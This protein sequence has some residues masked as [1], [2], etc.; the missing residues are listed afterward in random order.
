ME[1]FSDIA[2]R[3]MILDIS[4]LLITPLIALHR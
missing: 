1:S 3:A 2:G 4:A